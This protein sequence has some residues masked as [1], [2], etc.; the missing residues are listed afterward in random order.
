MEMLC[1]R[2]N[3]NGTEWFAS[4]VGIIKTE[5]KGGQ[6]VLTAVHSLIAGII[7]FSKNQDFSLAF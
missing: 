2:R 5:G 4:V 6:A 7:P 1:F 3:I